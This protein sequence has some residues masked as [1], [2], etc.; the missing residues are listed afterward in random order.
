VDIA[1]ADGKERV[2][3]RLIAW[4]DMSSLFLWVT[5]VLLG[6]GKGVLQADVAQSLADLTMCSH[7]GI[8][9][10]FYLD[11][12]GEYS[13]LAE[14][15][16]RLSLL[17]ERQ[18]GLTL[19]K[20]YSPTSKGSI[21]GAFNVLEGLFKGLPGWIGGR[22]DNKK[23]ANKGMVVAPYARG[24][25]QLVADV[26]ACVAI[27]NSRPQGS[28]SRIAGLSPKDVLEMKIEATGYAARVPSDDVFDL[29]FSRME[30]RTVNQASVQIDNRVY[31]GDCLH[32]VMPGTKVKVI[33]PLREGR[34]C[35]WVDVPGKGSQPVQMAPTFAYGDRDGARYQ[36]GL[37]AASNRAVRELARDVDPVVSTFDMQKRA[38]DMTPPRANAPEKWTGMGVIDKTRFRKSEA[39]LR[40]EE[41][42]QRNQRFLSILQ[43]ETAERERAIG[44][45][46]R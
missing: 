22:R 43:Q 38:A 16:A 33:L 32:R 37:E 14:A 1:I 19:A 25:E 29:I 11:N 3:L 40:V 10:Q 36:D 21:E 12:G 13:A 5:P 8:P 7:G 18:F 17:S 9:D 46:N 26:H 15:M 20:P 6:Q 41:I 24:L 35:A 44:G 2:R 4:M 30:E 28:G 45:C 31:Q 27:Y 42:S 34:D 39:E 23:T